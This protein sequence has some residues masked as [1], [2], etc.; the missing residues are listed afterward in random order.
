MVDIHCHILPEVDDGARDWDIATEMC[1]MAAADGIDHIVAT[2]HA[3][4]EYVYDRTQLEQTLARLKTIAGGMLNFSLGC[5]FHF[6]YENIH[7]AL[8]NP[9]RY[10]IG[11]TRYLLVEFSDFAIS[12][13]T[14]E[15][16][17]ALMDSGL[18]PIITHPER[19]AI[20]ARNPK[21]VLEWAAMGVLV[22]VT[23][24][25]MTGRWGKGAKDA[26]VFLAKNRAVH[27]LASD[28]H[29]PR[30]RPPVLSQGRD[31]MAKVVGRAAADAM[32]EDV[33]RAII[34]N[35]P[36]PVIPVK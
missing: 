7:D 27:V 4:H 24:N 19:N 11:S 9:E 32:V 34:S 13:N 25:A 12:P 26:A 15:H 10:C 2:P 22:Q 36:V 28:A 21:Q 20:L 6:S 3:N 35:Q 29:D 14:G 8:L 33:P 31:E 17:R 1:R 16:L 23:A 18:T 30:S 5:D